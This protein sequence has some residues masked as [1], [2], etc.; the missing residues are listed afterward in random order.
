MIPSSGLIGINMKKSSTALNSS[1]KP[2]IC[3][4][5]SGWTE[6]EDV[7]GEPNWNLVIIIDRHVSFLEITVKKIKGAVVATSG[8]VLHVVK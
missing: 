2:S 6:M 4:A 1:S 8:E 3:W 5:T 7:A